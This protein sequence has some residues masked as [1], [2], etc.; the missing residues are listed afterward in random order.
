MCLVLVHHE[1]LSDSDVHGE[2]QLILVIADTKSFLAS[3]IAVL[4]GI[5]AVVPA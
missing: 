2:V 3:I 1:A 4:G 5:A